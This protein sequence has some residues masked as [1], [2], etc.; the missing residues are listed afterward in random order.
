MAEVVMEEALRA[1]DVVGGG[2]DGFGAYEGPIVVVTAV[3]VSPC[4]P[5]FQQH[6]VLTVFHK[7]PTRCPVCE[8]AVLFH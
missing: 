8:R 2:H 7:R 3:T 6:A 1:G 4:Q 5:I